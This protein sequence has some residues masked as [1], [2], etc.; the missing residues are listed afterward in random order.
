M[1]FYIFGGSNSIFRDGWVTSFS[2]C[3]DQP[4]FN[5]SVGATTTLTGLFRFL[6]LG[7]EKGPAENDCVLWEYALNEVNHVPRGYRHEML[8]KNVEHF[9]ALCRERGCRFIPLIF[10]PLWQEKMP[11]RDPYYGM[12]ADIF[13]HYGVIPFDVS[14]AWRQ[15][16][17]VKRMLD[18]FYVN[19]P[20]YIRTSQLMEFISAGVADL[21][22][23]ARVP[24]P[25][26]PIHTEGRNVALI[27]G[28]EQD[29]FENSLMR[30]PTAQLPLSIELKQ[31]GRVAAICALCHSDFE[32]G[33]RVRLLSGTDRMRQMRFSTTNQ[34]ARRIILKAV[35]LEHALGNRWTSHWSF[36]PGD[37]LLL[38]PARKPGQFY[39]EHELR[40][41]L[42]APEHK[43]P[44]RIS[45]VL[46]ESA[47]PAS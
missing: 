47:L 24:A 35:S 33:I 12:L 4:I 15:R 1:S 40:S 20:H 44:A 14:Q 32:S 29:E 2:E 26:A 34:N 37:R 43:A 10:T 41:A 11:Q 21:V 7:T 17:G 45:G 25:V 13:A 16:F 38:S 9:M 23:T 22:S 28:L 19:N 42:T 5:C 18:E 3:V 6:M 39:A 46:V 8:L 27:E 31:Q 30:V 36:T